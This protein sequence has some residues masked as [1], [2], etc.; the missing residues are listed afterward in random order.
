MKI[1]CQGILL[2]FV[3]I[4]ASEIFDAGGVF[5]K[6]GDAQQLFRGQGAADFE[7]AQAHAEGLI[8]A[9]IQAAFLENSGQGICSFGLGL[10]DLCK[11]GHGHE[12]PA[13]LSSGVRG[14]FLFQHMNDFI[15]F[16]YA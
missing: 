10:F 6:T 3:L 2:F 4:G 11:I 1:F 13:K 15:I 16:Q 14:C 9:E 8:A 12:I 5:Q 7:G